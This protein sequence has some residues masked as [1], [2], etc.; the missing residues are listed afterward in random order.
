M[1]AISLQ[2]WATK[3]DAWATK[4]AV[5]GGKSGPLEW[6]LLGLSDSLPAKPTQVFQQASSNTFNT[7]LARPFFE[8]CLFDVMLNFA[9]LKGDDA[10][11]IP[12]DPDAVKTLL[13]QVTL[14]AV[15]SKVIIAP[16]FY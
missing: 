16:Y 14:R 12:P 13:D 8:H 6:V 1:F 5:H 2:F 7:S 9:D 3:L 15:R 10:D 4:D 11:R